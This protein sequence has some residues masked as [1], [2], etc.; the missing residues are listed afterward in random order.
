MNLNMLRNLYASALIEQS[1]GLNPNFSK[2]VAGA[3]A[4]A[5][6]N[7]NAISEP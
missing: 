5:P 1:F 7:I 2:T 3:R 4:Q 6:S